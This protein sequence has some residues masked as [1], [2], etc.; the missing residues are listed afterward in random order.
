M[1]SA[2][3]QLVANIVKGVGKGAEKGEPG[4]YP[5]VRPLHQTIKYMTD[6]EAKETTLPGGEFTRTATDPLMWSTLGGGALAWILKNKSAA[7]IME[8]AARSP[9]LKSMMERLPGLGGAKKITAPMGRTAASG[10]IA[11]TP[12]ALIPKYSELAP[13]NQTLYREVSAWPSL[14]MNVPQSQIPEYARTYVSSLKPQR[15]MMGEMLTTPKGQ[16]KVSGWLEQPPHL[17]ARPKGEGP[18]YSTEFGTQPP[19]VVEEMTQG[20]EWVAEPGQTKMGYESLES[21]ISAATEDINKGLSMPPVIQKK[22]KAVPKVP[23]KR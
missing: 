16:A 6:P 9:W 23:K 17:R 3:Q 12:G 15:K 2:P 5:A 14:K 18:V 7:E 11:R 20:K 22:A 21:Q 4:W 13:K 8:M 1:L 19:S 10:A